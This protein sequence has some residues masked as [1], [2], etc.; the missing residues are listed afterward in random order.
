MN[1]VCKIL[2]LV[3]NLF[4]AVLNVAVEAVNALVGAA[5]SVLDS[6]AGKLFSGNFGKL[7]LIGLGAWLL[8]GAKKD[9]KTNINVGATT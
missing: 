2:N 5:L 1:I 7:A 6:T 4:T 8:L 3:L 9:K